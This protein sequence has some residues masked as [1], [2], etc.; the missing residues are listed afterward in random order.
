[1]LKSARRGC[2]RQQ[3][4]KRLPEIRTPAPP[5]RPMVSTLLVALLLLANR[6][7]AS[8]SRGRGRRAAL[9]SLPAWLVVSCTRLQNAAP[10]QIEQ[11]ILT[12]S[13]SLAAPLLENRVVCCL[14]KHAYKDW[15]LVCSSEGNEFEE[16]GGTAV[17]TLRFN[18]I[19]AA[20]QLYI[21]PLPPSTTS[22]T[23]H[24]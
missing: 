19:L 6:T 1:M 12:L 10:R 2:N 21:P 4:G 20:L 9:S 18:H 15:L 7:L 8:P 11:Y 24:M 13:A 5:P 22:P 23:T 17:F 3:K 14:E 16:M